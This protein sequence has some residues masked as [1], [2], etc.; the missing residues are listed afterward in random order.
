MHAIKKQKY[1]SGWFYT[2]VMI[3]STG[4]LLTKLVW[5]FLNLQEQMLGPMTLI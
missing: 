3:N 2:R 1:A 5:C 4:F